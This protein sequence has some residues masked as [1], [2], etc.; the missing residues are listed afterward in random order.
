LHTAPAA[1]TDNVS[2]WADDK[3]IGEHAD[4]GDSQGG[5]ETV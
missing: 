1:A 3:N 4:K 2:K 5:S